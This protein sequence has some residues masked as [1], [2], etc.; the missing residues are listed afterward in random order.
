M[1]TGSDNEVLARLLDRLDQLETD[2][3][4]L[5]AEMSA[6]RP[7]RPAPNTR[8]SAED[9]GG[10]EPADDHEQALS[11]R[12]MLSRLA[13]A[14]A[15]GLGLAAGASL[16]AAKPA[17]AAHNGA[18]QLGHEND[19]G[20]AA[21][22][23]DASTGGGPTLSLL[24]AGGGAAL[25]AESIDGIGVYAFG[26]HAPLWL[27]PSMT[28]GPPTGGGWHFVGEVMVDSTG[29]VF[30]SRQSGDP[31]LWTRVGF[32]GVTPTRIADTRPG[33]GTP[34]STGPIG[35]GAER[36]I[37]VAGVAGVPAQ[38]GGVVMNATAVA[39]TASSYLTIYPSGVARP[40]ASNLN[41]VAG[42][43]PTPNLVIV[44][45]GT[46]G[47]VRVY[48]NSGSV[49]VILDVAGFFS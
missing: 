20:G 49:Q 17:G 32:N 1:I 3:A 12:G 10:V 24:D 9:R 41:V 28:A 39:P 8:A 27:D 44:K 15:A 47:K 6:L 38:A 40:V 34:Y 48:N 18:L 30:V 16:L 14:G 29:A 5:R 21:T 23:L 35:P 7:R 22:F 13:G 2:N 37:T 4:E 11:R 19:A 45:L 31:G 42:G 25:A 33:T 46:G 26:G 36:E 43:P